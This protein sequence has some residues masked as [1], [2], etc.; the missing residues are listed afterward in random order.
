MLLSCAKTGFTC[1]TKHFRGIYFYGPKFSKANIRAH[2]I[3]EH[4]LLAKGTRSGERRRWE[5]NKEQMTG[6]EGI[7]RQE[8]QLGPYHNICTDFL[9]IST[10]AVC[11][12]TESRRQRRRRVGNE[13]LSSPA[14]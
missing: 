2:S 11:G 3:S 6:R 14:D 10:G 13:G 12:V 1:V 8:A 5:E 9:T 7:V 4:F